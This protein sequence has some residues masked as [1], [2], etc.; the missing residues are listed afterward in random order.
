MDDRDSELY[1][2]VTAPNP[3]LLL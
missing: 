1:D 3:F 2:A